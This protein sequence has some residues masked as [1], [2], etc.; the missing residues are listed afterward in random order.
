MMNE[1]KVQDYFLI[2]EIANVMRYSPSRLYTRINERRLIISKG[3]VSLREFVN[4][5]EPNG[6]NREE[7]YNI[8]FR[9]LK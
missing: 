7:I 8:L 3:K 9:L 5:L 1:R 4:I 2:S 6:I